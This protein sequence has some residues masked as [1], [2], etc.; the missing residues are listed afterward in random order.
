MFFIDVFSNNIVS[1]DFLVDVFLL[2]F[3]YLVKVERLDLSYNYLECFFF[4]FCDVMF[5]LKYVNLSYNEFKDFFFC[6]VY[7]LSRVKVLNLLYNKIEMKFYFLFCG[8]NSMMLEDLNLLYNGEIC[9][10][11][12]LG[13]LFFGLISLYVLGN[14]IKMLFDC[15]LNLL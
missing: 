13:E 10:F 9:F 11:E 1:I 7:E 14:S 6:F 8:L 15:F 5:V 2:F 12:R 4:F 3:V